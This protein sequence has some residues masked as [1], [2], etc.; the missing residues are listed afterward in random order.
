MNEYCKIQS[1]WKRDTKGKVIQGDYSLPVFEYLK[2]NL[3]EFTEKVDGT[4]IRIA[5]RNGQVSFGGRTDNAQIP[6]KLGNYLKDW[7]T[8][9]RLAPI[10]PDC[11]DVDVVLYGEGYGAGIQKG[12][13][14][15]SQEQ[16]FILFDVKIG[17]WLERKNVYDIARKLGVSDV[18]PILQSTLAEAESKVR[19]GFLSRVA[20]NS[21][22]G[23]KAEGLVGRPLEEL[24]TRNGERVIVKMKTRDYNVE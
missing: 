11:K 7:F 15:Y 18:P 19:N 12:G 8:V 5:Y 20:Q 4:N 2:N 10:F 1:L 6:A 9:E 22:P 3:W 16:S 21:S 13:G 23:F 17:L 24:L 14:N